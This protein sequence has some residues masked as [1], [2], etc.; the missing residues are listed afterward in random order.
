MSASVSLGWGLKIYTSNKSQGH[1]DAF[2]LGDHTCR[3]NGPKFRVL[4]DRAD[5]GERYRWKLCMEE[6]KEG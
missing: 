1:G 4:T 6:E 5:W 3:I 2:G